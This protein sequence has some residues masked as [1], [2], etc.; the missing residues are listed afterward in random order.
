MTPALRIGS[1]RGVRREDQVDDRSEASGE[2]PRLPTVPKRRLGRTEMSVSAIGLGLWGMSGWSGRDDERS[3]AVL[4]RS[5]E[6]GCNF[7]DTAWAYGDGASDRLLGALYHEVD[8]APIHMASKVPPLNAHWPARRSD[9]FDEVFPRRYV[10]EMVDRIR[11]ALRVDTVP[12]LQL[13]VWD[14]HWAADREFRLLVEELKSDGLIDNFGLSLNRWE[15]WNGLAAIQT[16][17]IDTVQVIYNIFDQAPEDEL[18]PAC[19]EADVGVIARVPLDEGSL[20]GQMSTATRFPDGD[21]RARYFGP[22]NLPGTIDRVEALR[23]LVPE[24]MTLAEM[25]LRF[26]LS[27]PRVSTTIVG[28]RSE[29][30]LRASTTGELDRALLDQLRSHRWD[31]V[32]ASWSD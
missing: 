28:V 22:E 19:V 11:A 2:L 21:W 26:V 9:A 27:D 3:A 8:A 7:F 29:S 12:I 23:S 10:K 32:P 24:Q 31:R 30:N 17:L 16:G 14:D 18:F 25:A 6:L 15:P 5:V 1:F 13:H 20:G 4:R